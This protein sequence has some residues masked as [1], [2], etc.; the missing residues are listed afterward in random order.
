M[1]LHKVILFKTDTCLTY[2]LRR[3]GKLELVNEVNYE[4]I[5]DHFLS[6]QFTEKLKNK[7]Q[8][9]DMLLWQRDVKYV[10]MPWEIDIEGKILWHRK[11][12]GSHVAVYEGNGIISDNT[13]LIYPPH[14]NL[15]VR[16]LEQLNKMPDYVLRFSND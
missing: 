10:D 7:L 11:I 16:K 4:N 6:F 15:R 1:E 13:R 3:I 5:H 14:P 9:G 12:T 8:V 2:A